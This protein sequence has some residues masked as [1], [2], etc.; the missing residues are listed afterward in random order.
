[1]LNDP[2]VWDRVRLVEAREQSVGSHQA[3]GVVRHYQRRTHELVVPIDRDEHHF[4]IGAKI[5]GLPNATTKDT[6]F[7]TALS[8]HRNFPAEEAED[9]THPH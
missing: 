7:T 1:M 5:G 9:A 4:T 3:A 2:Q 8:H 6:T